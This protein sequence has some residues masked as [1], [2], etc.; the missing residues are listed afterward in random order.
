MK[1]RV[2]ITPDRSGIAG[3]SAPFFAGGAVGVSGTAGVSRCRENAAT[4]V[5]STTRTR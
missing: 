1:L 3:A 5:M 2:F 4:T